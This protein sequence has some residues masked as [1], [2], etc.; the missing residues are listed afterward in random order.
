MEGNDFKIETVQLQEVSF[1]AA[2]KMLMANMEIYVEDIC[3]ENLRLLPVSAIQAHPQ[4]NGN[5]IYYY[6]T[7]FQSQ[8]P[9]TPDHKFFLRI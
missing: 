2:A 6:E 9:V 8:I 7:D 4:P 1:L 5:L 3:G